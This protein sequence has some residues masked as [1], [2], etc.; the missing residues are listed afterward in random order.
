MMNTL[1][2]E[3]PNRAPPAAAEL[4]LAVDTRAQQRMLLRVGA[5]GLLVPWDGGREVA[6]VPPTSRVPNTPAWLRGLANV[7]GGLVPVVDVAAAFGLARASARTD[8]LLICGQGETAIGLLIDGLPRAFDVDAAAP[9]A[10][11][12]PLPAALAAC[13]RARYRHADGVVLDMD[14][15]SLFD[16]LGQQLART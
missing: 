5:L 10:E 16:A 13:V 3:T 4:D 14:L 2:T 15:P 8:Y 9:L 7:R 6:P 11:D 12:A 1:A